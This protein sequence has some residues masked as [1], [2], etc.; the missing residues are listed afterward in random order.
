MPKRISIVGRTFGRLKVTEDGPSVFRGGKWRSV[1]ICKCSCGKAARVCNESLKDGSTRSCGCLRDESR[2]I[3][4][5]IHGHAP[6][7]P[8]SRTY[9]IW[10]N[11][12]ARCRTKSS[13][14]FERY[15]AKGVN[16]CERWLEFTNFLEDMGECPPRLTIDRFPNNTGNYEPSNCRWA[17]TKQQAR[18]KTNNQLVTFHGFT[19]CLVEVC[20]HFNV[21]Y[22]AIRKRINLLHWDLERAFTAPVKPSSLAAPRQSVVPRQEHQLPAPQIPTHGHTEL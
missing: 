12:L 22:E 1:S 21:N 4:K 5:F 19:G 18:N 9:M 11:M 2:I 16:V 17:T 13:S 14:S 15:G 7:G 6:T 8:K 10:T 3:T 20:E